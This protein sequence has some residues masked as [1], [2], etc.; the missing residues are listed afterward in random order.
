MIDI[1]LSGGG[2]TG[3]AIK[4][5]HYPPYVKLA[6][7]KAIGM[8]QDDS[9]NNAQGS[10]YPSNLNT[11]LTSQTQIT[12]LFSTEALQ[13]YSLDDDQYDVNESKLKVAEAFFTK[14]KKIVSLL[15]S[16]FTSG[17]RSL[18][19][20]VATTYNIFRVEWLDATRFAMLY[21][22][23]TSGYV[24]KLVVGQIGS[25]GLVTFGSNVTI[26]TYTDATHANY[27]AAGM[28]LTDTDKL[29]VT[30]STKVSTN[31]LLK[32]RV[33]TVSGTTA[34]PQSEGADNTNWG[35]SG[36]YQIQMI[37]V[38]GSAGA[39]AVAAITPNTSGTSTP[40]R[41]Q[42]ISHDNANSISYGGVGTVVPSTD[43]AGG[44]SLHSYATDKLVMT[45]K[46]SGSAQVY[47]QIYTISGTTATA[48]GSPLQ[49]TTSASA[50][51]IL[52]TKAHLGWINFGSNVLG[53][54][55]NNANNGYRVYSMSVASDTLAMLDEG[56][57]A[58]NISYLSGN[59]TS[60]VQ[61][62]TRAD[63][64]GLV[65]GQV[66]GGNNPQATWE[67]TY[68]GGRAVV[69]TSITINHDL[70][71][72]YAAGTWP[73]TKKVLFMDTNTNY[74]QTLK[75]QIG[76]GDGT[77]QVLDSANAVL[78]TITE[79]DT[80]GGNTRL[81]LLNLAWANTSRLIFKLKNTSSQARIIK[82]AAVYVEVE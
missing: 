4:S 51:H 6:D 50:S 3:G 72:N 57:G 64:T 11:S 2:S 19:T 25:D 37:K 63:G 65:Y 44:M 16:T 31:Y 73:S 45:S 13:Y 48:V 10:L 54:I 23:Q 33:V 36:P 61:A 22:D 41:V 18:P 12:T 58:N 75:Y 14:Y 40:S 62:I 74:N 68:T 39:G 67:V 7:N 69:Q 20:S 21:M 42:I 8:S 30:Y 59:N 49:I 17:P 82:V 53:M 66:S 76:A 81:K 79:T 26:K 56:N 1:S 28:A 34:T 24:L 9:S 55:F 60:D 70:G 29:L 46:Q 27:A 43:A 78:A 80:G 47:S 38:R 15:Y 5:V 52:P 77:I 32:A 71:S 35:T